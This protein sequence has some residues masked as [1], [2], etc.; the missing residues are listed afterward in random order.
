VTFVDPSQRTPTFKRFF[1][2]FQVRY[3]SVVLLILTTLT[4]P[5]HDELV[6]LLSKA[7][8]DIVYRYLLHIDDFDRL[9]RMWIK[10]AASA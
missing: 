2:L 5:A 3:Y 8:R 7:D 1:G 6:T 9:H 4:S 10:V